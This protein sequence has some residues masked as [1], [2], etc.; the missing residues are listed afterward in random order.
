M[1]KPQTSNFDQ[2]Q[3]GLEI[4]KIA[5]LAELRQRPDGMTNA[6]LT[7]QLGL[8]SDSEG[9]MRNYLCWS[10]LGILI[11]EKR[12]RSVGSGHGRAYRLL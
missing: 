7:H 3:L 12:V 6:E 5:I 10:I 11:R 9:K 8:E 2:A 4:I 1:A